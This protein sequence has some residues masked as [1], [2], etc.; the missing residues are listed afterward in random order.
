MN[1]NRITSINA[2]TQNIKSDLVVMAKLN[3]ASG[4]GAVA[5]DLGLKT[6]KTKPVPAY[7]IMRHK[8]YHKEVIPYT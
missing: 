6:V 2:G 7:S 4:V 3:I 1:H 8:I 5:G